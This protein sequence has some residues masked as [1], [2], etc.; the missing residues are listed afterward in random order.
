MCQSR[1]P[2]GRDQERGGGPCEGSFRSTVTTTETALVRGA[3]GAGWRQSAPTGAEAPKDATFL[4]LVSVR[5]GPDKR[6]VD[7]SNPSGPTAQKA[8]HDGASVHL[9]ARLRTGRGGSWIQG[10]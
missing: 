4:A 9:G 8:P 6:E 3:V 7:G 1:P 2:G 5:L 10:R